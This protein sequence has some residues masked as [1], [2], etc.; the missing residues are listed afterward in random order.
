MTVHKLYC[1]S[2]A[3]KEGTHSD[4]VWQPDR[5]IG[6]TEKA[7]AFI[8]SVHLPVVWE[9]ITETNKYLYAT[10]TL[11]FL[12]VLNS[13]NKLYLLENGTNQR[14]ISLDPAIYDGA[15]L[16]ANL[17]AKLSA[18]GSLA[19][20]WS[21]DYITDGTTLGSMQIEAVGL[22]SWKL[23][24]RRE[25]IGLDSWGGIT[26]NKLALN[27]TYD[28]FGLVESS[29]TAATSHTFALS[30]A[31]GYRQ[32]ALDKGFYTFDELALQLQS[33]MN[34]GS[35][36]NSGAYTVTAQTLTGRLK[37][38]NSSTDQI[39]EIYPEAYLTK[40]PYMF[41]EVG[42]DPYSSDDVTGLSGDHI[43]Q[44]NLLTAS[45]HVN[46][47]RYHS[48]FITSDLGTHADSVGPRGQS[49]VARK[50]VIDQPAGGFVNDFHSL[51]FDYVALDKQSIAAIHFRLTD[52]RGRT[53][54]MPAPW[55]LSV[56]IVPESDF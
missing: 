36:I 24:S 39:F 31:K 35:A 4:W 55:S 44:G 6:I 45:M 40:N 26:L 7:R 33:K 37:V 54:D 53:V 11:P 46:V 8:D 2:R 50:I 47:L 43:L 42:T 32:I 52:W 20:S 9:T 5:P 19:S 28:I 22:T 18:S 29:V 14:T 13:T 12:T 27:D 3:R 41:L 30:S 25:M 51:P 15:A 23:V 1:D 10:E 16:R 49:S 48:L 34:T 56:I 38:E 21:V 17:A